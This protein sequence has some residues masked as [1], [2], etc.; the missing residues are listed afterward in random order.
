MV[1]SAFSDFFA[2]LVKLM[3][4]Y[5]PL[6]EAL[7]NRLYSS[8]TVIVLVW[9]GVQTA[10]RGRVEMDKFA[11][12]ILSISFGFAMLRFYT[13]PIPGF[14]VSFQHLIFDQGT[15]LAHQINQTMTETVVTGLDQLYMGLETPGVSTVLNI[16]EVLRWIVTVLIILAAEATVFLVISFG[17]AASGVCMLLGPVFIP[18]FIV[19]TMEWMFWG[20]LRAFLQYSFYPVVANAYVFV[21]GNM[22]I[23][24]IDTAGTDF[25]G[26]K[27]A[28]YFGSF[29]FLM[30]AFILGLLKVPSIRQQH[31]HRKSR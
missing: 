13:A 26:A 11:S 3:T 6:F 4:D 10:L 14:G 22:I 31:L 8:F 7:G 20:W 17:Y 29:F 19:P 16:I 9:F 15:F 2:H 27:L 30:T 5:S 18:F 12:M 21:F 1:P 25:S 23:R 28:V 24:F